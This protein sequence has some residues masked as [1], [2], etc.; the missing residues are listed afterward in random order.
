MRK[1]SEARAME[2]FR[3]G[4]GGQSVKTMEG[5]RAK[6]MSR[7]INMKTKKAK[8]QRASKISVEGRGI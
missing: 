3:S 4:L 1:G 8:N 5:A 6:M 2:R 7:M